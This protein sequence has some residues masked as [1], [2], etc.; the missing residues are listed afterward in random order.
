MREERRR[1]RAAL[2]GLVGLSESLLLKLLR[3]G[4]ERELVLRNR[5]RE[6]TLMRKR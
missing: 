3:S 1:L 2:H 6:M 4:S 5:R